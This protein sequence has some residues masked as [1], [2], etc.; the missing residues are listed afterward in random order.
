MY[1]K[2]KYDHKIRFQIKLEDVS[3]EEYCIQQL[4]NSQPNPY[5]TEIILENFFNT[6]NVYQPEDRT[7]NENLFL[8]DLR[9]YSLREQN[10]TV[11]LSTHLLEN[12]EIFK[13]FIDTF[14]G[15]KA[16]QNY[17]TYICFKFKRQL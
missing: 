9:Y 4:M 2:F 15:G 1:S 6:K 3:S 10:D 8:K 7:I 14:S 16:F 12:E 11:T 13:F 17:C 5:S